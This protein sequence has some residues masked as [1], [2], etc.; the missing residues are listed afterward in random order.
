LSENAADTQARR[1]SDSG[2][3]ADRQLRRGTG[4]AGLA[5]LP[6]IFIPGIAGS[7]QEPG[8]TG[9]ADQVGDFFRSVDTTM[10]SLGSFAS[11]LGVMAFLWFAIGLSL[12]LRAAEV[13]PRWR[14]TLAGASAVVFVAVA[15]GGSWTAATLR[16][17][18]LDPDVGRFAFDLGNASFANG[19][20][21]MGSFAFCVGWGIVSAGGLP[22]WL[23]WWAIIAGVGL[24]LSR[25]MW[26]SE[27]WLLP[28][29]LFWAWLIVV[30]VML[31]RPAWK[32]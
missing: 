26:T 27:I 23:G 32:S 10:G 1:S 12:H 3:R 11:T 22:K 6:L 15:L 31:L 25:A 5:A 13:D 20:V 2:A 29:A 19:W 30:C 8:F 4:L 18:S 17:G 21:A 16:S 9:T 7:S 14:S 24:A 28:Y